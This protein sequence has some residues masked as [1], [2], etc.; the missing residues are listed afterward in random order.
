MDYMPLLLPAPH[1]TDPRSRTRTDDGD[2]SGTRLRC[3]GCTRKDGLE[4][5]KRKLRDRPRSRRQSGDEGLAG[6]SRCIFICACRGAAVTRARIAVITFF[7]KS[8]DTI[9]A[10][11][12]C[13]IRHTERIRTIHTSDITLFTLFYD[14]IPAERCRSH[15][16]GRCLAFDHTS[17][18]ATIAAPGIAVVTLFH[19]IPNMISTMRTN[20]AHAAGICSDIG[21]E[22][23]AVALFT[24]LLHPVAAVPISGDQTGGFR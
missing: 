17:G 18:V 24:R 5:C 9:A 14:T 3:F 8:D 11:T 6:W 1:P 7:G 23:S 16:H 12:P 20:T 10:T 2:G 21:V 15:P 13:A 4:L 19:R 22:R